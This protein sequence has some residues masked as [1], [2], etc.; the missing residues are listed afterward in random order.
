MIETTLAA[1]LATPQKVATRRPRK[2]SLKN[3][4]K[5]NG[6]WYFKK[7]VKGKREF[8]GRKTPF[9]LETRDE[10]VAKAKRDAILRAANGSDKSDKQRSDPL[11]SAEIWYMHGDS[12]VNG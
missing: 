5:V 10:N 7:F 12:S 9:S 6:I 11:R 4:M 3:L 1:E 2:A 8:N